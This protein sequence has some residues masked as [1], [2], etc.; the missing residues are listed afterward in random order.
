MFAAYSLENGEGHVKTDFTFEISP[1]VRVF[2]ATKS[3]QF[4]N[5][6]GKIVRMEQEAHQTLPGRS[7]FC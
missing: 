6:F 4:R 5:F 3:L 1:S 2:L 7:E